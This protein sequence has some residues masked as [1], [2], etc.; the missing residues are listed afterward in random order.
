VAATGKTARRWNGGRWALMA[1]IVCVSVGVLV[2]T[3]IGL[4]SGAN[5]TDSDVTAGHITIGLDDPAHGSAMTVDATDIAPTDV[6]ERVV[7]LDVSG[8]V[9]ISALKLTT[10]APTTT[11]ALDTD[12]THG[13]QLKIEVCD[14]AWDPDDEGHPYKCGSGDVGNEQTA[15]ASRAVIGSNLTLNNLNLSGN[16]HLLV[17]MTLAGGSADD[18]ATFGDASSTIHFAFSGTQRSSQYK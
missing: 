11:S 9:A 2:F 13:L 17:T 5:S 15:L 10:T 1:G 6:I 18:D 12:A 7:D 16:N 14:Q 4:F 3:A 8:G